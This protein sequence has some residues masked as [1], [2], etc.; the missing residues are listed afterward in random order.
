MSDTFTDWIGHPAI[1]YKSQPGNDPVEAL[2]R[3]IQEGAAHL[4][5]NGPS[6]YLRA[7]LDALDVPLESQIAVFV[8]DSVQGKRISAGNPRTLFF[9]DS[10]AVGW[11]RGGFI[12]LAA[13]DPQQGVHFYTLDA[14]ETTTPQFRRRDECLVCHYSF[15]TAG[16]PGMLARSSGQFAV[17]HTLSFDQRWGGWYVTGDSGSIHHLG[18]VPLDRLFQSPLSTQTARSNSFERKFDTTGYLSTH[19][20]IVALAVFEHQ[21]HLMNLLTR[22]GWEARVAD[23]AKGLASAPP[24]QRSDVQADLPIPLDDA[25]REL[26]DYMLF[27]DEAPLPAP[28]KGS[29]GFAERF[30]ARGPRDRRGRSLRALDLKTRLVRYRCSYMIYTEA[31]DRLPESARSA[32][33]RRLWQVL[34]GDQKGARYSRLSVDDRQAI[35]EILRDTKKDLPAYFRGF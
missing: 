14:A 9:N 17:D 10:V 29:S 26:V 6:G 25:A 20:D 15:T 23:Y 27:V 13:H 35:V 18:N 24:D 7:V 8:P 12:E 4:A 21:M 19:S 11:V 30:E 3:R 31:F 2:N 28:I 32:V 1:A 5:F 16:V 22:I 34:S 33:Y